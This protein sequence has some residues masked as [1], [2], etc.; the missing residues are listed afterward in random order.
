[1]GLKEVW[2]L[3]CP[4][5]L[6]CSEGLLLFGGLPAHALSLLAFNF[7]RNLH[8]CPEALMCEWERGWGWT[9]EKVPESDPCVRREQTLSSRQGATPWGRLALGA[10]C[11]TPG[12]RAP[13]PSESPGCRRRIDS[14]TVYSFLK[15]RV[16]IPEVSILP[17]DLEELYD[18]FKVGKSGKGREGR[19][20]VDVAPAPVLWQRRLECPACPSV[21]TSPA[22]G[23][24]TE[25]GRSARRAFRAWDLVLTL[26]WVPG[27]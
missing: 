14:I 8:I 7:C 20:R 22:R 19:A 1:M 12:G 15:L 3:K 5:P 4:A 27:W 21:F 25:A 17:E 16:V 9:P 2:C 10:W 6:A 13:A 18:L 24:C 26:R 23:S 11:P